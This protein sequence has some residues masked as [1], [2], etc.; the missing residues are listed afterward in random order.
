VPL[1]TRQIP[2]PFAAR[3]HGLSAARRLV[4]GVLGASLASL[5]MVAA[6]LADATPIQL[7]LVYMPNV[8][9]SGTTNASGIAELVMPEGEVRIKATNLPRLDG[10][11]QYVPWV[12]DT[13]T[14]EFERLGAFNA[15]QSTGA[16][17]YETVLPEAIPSKHWNLFLVTIEDTAT[18]A[19]PSKRHSI[20]GAF[21]RP[22]SE[23]LPVVLPNTGGAPDGEL[24]A[25]SCQ[26][27]ACNGANWLARMGLP[28]LTLALGAGAGY[29]VGRRRLMRPI[30]DSR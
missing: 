23:P 21:P 20:A 29:I 27:S 14:N 11:K 5:S 24:S 12:I 13:E 6:A 9:N 19:S 8:S 7:V 17:R 1:C 25:V 3:G 22:D 15:A 26:P 30:A 2:H 28:A 16:V 18:P 10:D 4:I